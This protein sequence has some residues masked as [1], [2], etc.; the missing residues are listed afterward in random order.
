MDFLGT[1]V[2]L[3]KRYCPSDS[4]CI[5]FSVPFMHKLDCLN[6]RKIYHLKICENT[7]CGVDKQ[8]SVLIIQIMVLKERLSKK[9]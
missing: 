2:Y 4:F 5:F 9:K 6:E 8:Y 7:Y 1:N 3:L